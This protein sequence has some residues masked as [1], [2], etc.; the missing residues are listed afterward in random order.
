MNIEEA[1]RLV[2]FI[3][4]S[5]PSLSTPDKQDTLETTDVRA[6]LEKINQHLA[7]EHPQPGRM[8]GAPSRCKFLPIPYRADFVRSCDALR[9]AVGHF[10]AGA[11]DTP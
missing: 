1:G 3:A 11:Y 4:S 9:R 5:L 6:R 8:R 10:G 7:K 2:D